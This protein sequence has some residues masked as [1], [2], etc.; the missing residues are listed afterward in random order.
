MKRIISLITIL[1][2]CFSCVASAGTSIPRLTLESALKM[3]EE[4]DK[5]LKI[6]Q[7]NVPILQ[8]AYDDSKDD[9][10]KIPLRAFEYQYFYSSPPDYDAFLVQANKKLLT[11]LSNKLAIEEGEKTIEVSKATVDINLYDALFDY[12]KADAQYT[13]DIKELAIKTA[14]F[15]AAQLKFDQGLLSKNDLKTLEYEKDNSVLNLDIS[16]KAKK[17][18]LITLNTKLGKD[19]DSQIKKVSL[20]YLYKGLDVDSDTAICNAMLNRLEIIKANNQVTIKEKSRKIV[21]DYLNDDTSSQYKTADLELK[22]AQYDLESKK[23][24]IENE[25]KAGYNNLLNL[26]DTIDINKKDASKKSIAYNA[27]KLKFNLNM[28]TKLELDSSKLDYEKAKLT[29]NDSILDYISAKY[30]FDMAQKSGP[31]I[32]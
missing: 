12:A 15:D 26:L 27:M 32:P 22:E 28:I 5:Q 9:A 20:K 10:N 29:L 1:C 8:K 3:A 25:I 19:L 11:P 13:I 7:N 4:T 30:K 2:I 16:S 14:S 6:D 31:A 24:D 21:K 18:A 23:I 17:R